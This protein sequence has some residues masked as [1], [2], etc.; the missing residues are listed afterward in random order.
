MTRQETVQEYKHRRT[1][2][3]DQVVVLLRE[4]INDGT[5]SAGGR[6][7]EEDLAA[8]VGTSRTPVREALQTLEREGLVNRRTGGGYEVR[9]FDSRELLELVGVWSVLEQYAVRLAGRR[10]SPEQ[11][12]GLADNLDRFAKAL[13]ARNAPDLVEL[14]AQFHETFYRAADNLILKRMLAQVS[15]SLHRFR[16]TL[17]S[18]FSSAEQA[19]SDHRAILDRLLAGDYDQAADAAHE[20]LLTGGRLMLACIGA[21]DDL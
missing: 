12:D 8:L 10:L 2:R 9:P 6:L 18:D 7:V 11:L 16:V 19:L 3:R 21:D 5:L 14:N 17:L 20:H 15:D 4:Y 1:N 13:A